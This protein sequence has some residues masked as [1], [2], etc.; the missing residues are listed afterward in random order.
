MNDYEL[1][2]AEVR[3]EIDAVDGEIH[4]LLMRRAELGRRIG[5]LKGPDAGVLWRPAREAQILRGLIERHSGPFPRRALVRI[6]REIVSATLAVQ[7]TLAVAVPASE[8]DHHAVAVARDHFGVAARIVTRPSPR[9]VVRAVAD[10]SAGVGLLPLPRDEE[11][12]PWWPALAA[13]GGGARPAVVARL[14]FAAPRDGLGDEADLLAVMIGA[15]EP[16]GADR[17]LLAVHL[18]EPWSRGRL[19]ELFSRHGLAPTMMIAETGVPP[20]GPGQ[21][22]LE[23]AGFVAGDDPRLTALAADGGA[24]VEEIRVLGG[25]A[26]PIAAAALGDAEPAA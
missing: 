22:L 15:F 17:T 23:V 9:G 19:S 6:W 5:A 24:P 3:R 11:T 25:Y 16:T 8:A 7:G 20:G 12:D 26:E 10:G 4:D 1:S 13:Q 18:A 21:L 14:P 2:L